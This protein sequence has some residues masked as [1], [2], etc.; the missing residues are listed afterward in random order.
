MYIV[1]AVLFFTEYYNV[2]IILIII[3][4]GVATPESNIKNSDLLIHKNIAWAM[5]AFVYYA[6]ISIGILK[7]SKEFFSLSF[8]V[9]LVVLLVPFIPDILLFEIYIYKKFKTG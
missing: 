3:T 1:C 9:M 8:A 6:V 5:F 4:L 7:F 2:G